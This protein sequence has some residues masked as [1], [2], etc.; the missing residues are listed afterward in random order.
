MVA[1]AGR[2]TLIGKTIWAYTVG[3]I[4][5]DTYTA[6]NTTFTQGFHQPDGFSFT[7]Y[8]P[9]ITDLAIYPNPARAGATLRFYLKVDKPQPLNISIYDGNGKLYQSLSI[10]SYAGQTYHSLNPQVMAAGVYQ[11]RLTV[12]SEKYYGRFVIIN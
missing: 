6:G 2:D 1:S 8:L 12:G 3:E 10:E 5:V 9:G 7:P 4:A 11:L